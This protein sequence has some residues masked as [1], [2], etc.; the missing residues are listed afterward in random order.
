MGQLDKKATLEEIEEK[1]RSYEGGIRVPYGA[2]RALIAASALGM[3]L[4]HLY[5]AGWGIREAMIQRTIHLAFALFLV[6][7]LYPAGKNAPKDRIPWYDILL[8][9]AG[10][11]VCVYIYTNYH[12]L[13]IRAGAP[14]LSDLLVGSVALF[15]VLEATRRSVG[16]ALVILA[17]VFFFYAMLGPWMPGPLLHRGFSLSKI[18]EHLYLT[19]E[20]IFGVP[21][22]VSATFVFVFI[23][24]GA[25]LEKT[26]AGTFFIDFALSVFGYMRGGPAKAAVVASGMMGSISGS[27]VANVV[28]TGTFT[29]PL[30]KKVGFAPH[31]AGGVEVAASTSGQ[32]M[33]PIMGAAAFIMAEYTNIPYVQIIKA[34]ALPAILNYCAILYMV[35]LE[36]CKTGI[37]G[38]PREELRSPWSVLK[39]GGHHLIPVVGIIY[40]LLRGFTPLKAAF[41][42]IMLAV[43]AGLLNRGESRLKFQDIISALENG[44]RNALSV[45]V[46]CAATGFIIGVVTLTGLGLRL[47]SLIIHWAA[48][49]LVLTL[50]FTMIASIILGM[51]LPTT[52]TYIVLATITAPALVRMN[53]PLIA[54]HLFVFYFGCAADDTP[55]VALAGY[56]AAGIAQSEPVRT[57]VMGFK[58]D[59]A[60]FLLPFTFVLAPALIFEGTGGWLETVHVFIT[61]CAGIMAFSA[62]IQNYFTTTCTWWERIILLA[63]ALVLIDP[64]WATDMIGAGLLLLVLISQRTRQTNVSS[65]G[66]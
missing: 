24:F 37:Q 8:S 51:G 10:V 31:V 2:W 4:F 42:G 48:G 38:I 20:G 22:G 46:A 57:G 39:E 41:I 5:T 13:M 17:S 26:G 15:L 49:N 1:I 30:M 54:A 40:M 43:V 28:T 6:F 12:A 11:G 32:I 35:H 52:A 29:I 18:V 62:C 16:L 56:A 33:P 64:S 36:A 47:S 44:A 7:L 25:F 61:A 66:I 14:T 63:V 21:L 50:F 27:S 9:L 55:P 65:A 34:A 19:T 59:F 3:S 23:L 60:A 45:A 53:V 58:F